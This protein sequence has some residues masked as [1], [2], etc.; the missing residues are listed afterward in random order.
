MN[1]KNQ[2]LKIALAKGSLLEP[3]LAALGRIGLDVSA[4]DPASRQ[5]KFDTPDA[6]FIIARATDVPTYVMYG[7]VDIGFA[8]KDVLMESQADVFELLDMGYGQCRFILAAPAESVTDVDDHYRRLGQTRVAT[9]Y[10]RVTEE[11]FER[12]GI[13]VEVIKLYGS[14]ELAPLVGLAEQIVDLTAT[15]QTLKENNLAIIDEIAPISCRLIANYVS[16]KLKSAEVGEVA[17]L[18]EKTTVSGGNN[19]SN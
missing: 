14:I 18:L 17:A 4:V 12:R 3:T 7:A 9:K 19:G 8:G 6:E 16:N 5:M 2:K 15:G 1:K 10:P 11:Y 13:Q